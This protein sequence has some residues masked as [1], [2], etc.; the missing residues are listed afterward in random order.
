MALAIEPMLNLGS[1]DV[2]ELSD[3]WTVVTKDGKRSAHF[4]QTVVVGKD[5]A[6]IL[7]E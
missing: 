1:Y 4:E 7:T 6:E 2:E 3:G 5:K